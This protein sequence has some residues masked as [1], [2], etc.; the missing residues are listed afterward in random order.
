MSG[1]VDSKQVVPESS[2]GNNCTP[3]PGTLTVTGLPLSPADLAVTAL[4]PPPATRLPGE[5]FSLTATIKNS[6][7]ATGP[8]PTTTGKFYLV[9]ALVNPTISKNLKGVQIVDPLAAGAIN[10]TAVTV[11]VTVTIPSSVPPGAYVV[12][13]CVDS[14]KLV[15]ETTDEIN[16]GTSVGII[17]VQ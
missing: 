1:C 16:C 15:P 4:T 9:N 2:D 10:A 3:A 11:P 17:Q 5:T 12:V 6:N 7:S 13:G 14:A 8:S